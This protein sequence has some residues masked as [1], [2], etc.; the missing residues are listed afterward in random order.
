MPVVPAGYTEEETSYR[1]PSY[2]PPAPTSN[3]PMVV[4]V[5]AYGASKKV[6][7]SWGDANE[8]SD[9]GDYYQVVV[10]PGYQVKIE[11]PG[12]VRTILPNNDYFDQTNG[13]VDTRGGDLN[14]SR[15]YAS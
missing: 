2:N 14:Q 13:Y 9:K 12:H 4:E 11:S 10:R 6:F 8:L 5:P 3:N 1:E 15:Q 7:L